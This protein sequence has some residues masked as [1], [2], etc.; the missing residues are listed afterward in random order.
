MV[1][2]RYCSSFAHLT[3]KVFT[4]AHSINNILRLLPICVFI[5]ATL[6]SSI[7]AQEEAISYVLVTES[8]IG[9]NKF[10]ESGRA[11]IEKAANH[12][13]A[14][15]LIFESTDPSTR[16][17]NVQAAIDMKAAIITVM[18]FGFDDIIT[19]LAPTSPDTR[20]I[21]IDTCLAEIPENVHCA[22]FREYEAAYMA[23]A[24]AALTSQSGIVGAIGALDTPFLHRYTDGFALGALQ[25]RPDIQVLPP[26][27]VGGNNPFQ[28]P[29]RAQ[30][31]AKLHLENGADRL[32]AVAVAGNGGIFKAVAEVPGAMAIGIDVNQCGDLPGAVLDS[33][34][35]HV[36]VILPAVI[37]DIVAGTAQ[38]VRSF[39]LAE[40]GLELVGLSDEI[41]NSGCMIA[42]N[43][44]V[45]EQLNTI[46]EQIITGLIT[47]D[48]PMMR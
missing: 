3:S 6:I 28:D 32:Y 42:E 45:I 26:L 34:L 48:D 16:R 46:Q 21:I 17:Q 18:G 44:D 19:D 31:Q 9:V 24:Q 29:V 20:F 8:R 41:A 15:A 37:D 43:K 12:H 36:E 23:G 25:T 38:P 33:T 7:K 22:V 27:W 39:G 2:I 14:R 5:S 4:Y 30:I 47:I 10:F 13:G 11:G 35:K 1:S 40:K